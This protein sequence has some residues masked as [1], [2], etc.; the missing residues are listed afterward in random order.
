MHLPPYLYLALL[1]ENRAWRCWVRQQFSFCSQNYLCC[2]LPNTL[3]LVF[4]NKTKAPTLFFFC[5]FSYLIQASFFTSSWCK[6]VSGALLLWYFSGWEVELQ[7]CDSFTSVQPD[8]H[9]MVS[10]PPGFCRCKCWVTN[11]LHLSGQERYPLSLLCALC[12]HGAHRVWAVRAAESKMC[13]LFGDFM[14]SLLSWSVPEA[15][16]G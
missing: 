14:F 3:Y 15:A 2:G 12:F 7:L 9:C 10:M 8:I 16:G 4:L 6:H 13:V 1:K 11:E 5:G